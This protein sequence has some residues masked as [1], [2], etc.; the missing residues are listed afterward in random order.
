MG[1]SQKGVAMRRTISKGA[2]KFSLLTLP[3]G[4]FLLSTASGAARIPD[5]HVGPSLLNNLKEGQN[6]TA[7]KPEP[8]TSADPQVKAVLDK[9]A[10][11]GIVHQTTVE[12]VRKAYLFYPKLS[13][14]AEH[15]FLIEDRQIPGPGG[16]IT[17]RVT[18]FI[19]LEDTPTMCRARMALLS[20]ARYKTK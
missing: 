1:K 19:R 5:E 11:A 13:G 12:D 7:T 3:L 14:P 6:Q 4:F 20:A 16:N 17:V 9:M 18:A 2:E 10:A 15:L 8:Q